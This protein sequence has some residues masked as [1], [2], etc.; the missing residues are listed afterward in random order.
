MT[1]A[2]GLDERVGRRRKPDPPVQ[3]RLVV[4]AGETVEL[5]PASAL[6]RAIGQL[7]GLLAHW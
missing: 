5:D 1:A 4:G 2:Y 6:A 3:V 7:A